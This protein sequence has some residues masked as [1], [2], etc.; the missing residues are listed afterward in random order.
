MFNEG[1]TKMTIG[2]D[3]LSFYKKIQPNFEK[4]FPELE[5]LED[6]FIRES[7]K[8]G[9]TYLNPIY[10]GKEGKNGLVLDVNSL[11]P[12]VM[13]NEKLP[14]GKPIYFTGK[15][16]E[17]NLYDLYVQ[18]IICSFELKENMIPTIQIKKNSLY[19]PTEY[20]TSSKGEIVCLTLTSVDLKLFLE[21]YN[22]Y[23]IEYL[24]GYKF[25]S[26]TG[27]FTTYIDYW[28]ANKIK[29]KKE[30]NFAM[31]RISK[32]MLNSLYGKFGLNPMQGSKMPYITEDDT[33]GYHILPKE[34]RKG[35]YIPIATFITSYGRKKTIETSQIISDYTRNKY[36]KDLYIYSDTDSIHVE[37]EK[38]DEL[39]EFVNIDD[40]IL[41]YWKEESHF[42]RGKYL[43]QKCY[44]EQNEDKL[45]T[46]IAGM[47]KKL[48][49][50]VNFD[51]FEEGF[52]TEKLNISEN[53][54][55]LT[56]KH[57]KGRCCTCTYRLYY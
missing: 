3:A 46:T 41:G 40:Y 49:K 7:Y 15:Y 27:F 1:L 37:L 55:K 18:K 43:R 10:K 6:T 31:Y 54:K 53:D 12:S 28:S 44:I 57:I 2:S 30:K 56:F 26:N 13:R 25:K 38:A 19:E 11:Y 35:I 50:Y 34:E 29:S 51:N 45:N 8:G 23:D 47:P 20:L 24:D 32:L 21:H 17:D 48:G 14:F 16:K 22:V 42:T 36:G 5:K 33:I 4:Y 39:K 9:F 52:T